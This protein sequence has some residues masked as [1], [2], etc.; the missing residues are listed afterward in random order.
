MNLSQWKRVKDSDVIL[1]NI[2]R[3]FE[4]TRAYDCRITM[5]L[6]IL[7]IGFAKD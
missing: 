5:E 4:A 6:K 7:R 2:G 1:A 3:G